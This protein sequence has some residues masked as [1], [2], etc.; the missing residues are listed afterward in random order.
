M[1][2]VIGASW[3]VVP[4]DMRSAVPAEWLA[5]AAVAMTVIG[6]VG[7]LVDQGGGNADRD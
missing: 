3:L 4:D 5:V 1:Q 6:I 2:G 7:R